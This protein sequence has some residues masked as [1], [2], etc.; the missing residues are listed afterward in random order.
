MALKPNPS[1][2]VLKM[3]GRLF[4]EQGQVI[5]EFNGLDVVRFKP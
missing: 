4:D 5:A 3:D 1:R 2:E